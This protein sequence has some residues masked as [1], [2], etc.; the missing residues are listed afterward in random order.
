[1]ERSNNA[2]W[3]STGLFSYWP[4]MWYGSATEHCD[5]CGRKNGQCGLREQFDGVVRRFRTASQRRWM[6]EEFGAWRTFC[7]CF[8]SP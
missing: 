3:G 5:G 8:G 6:P 4:I 7:D 2:G 1:M